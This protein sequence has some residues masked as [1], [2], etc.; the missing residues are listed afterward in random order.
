VFSTSTC[1]FYEKLQSDSNK[2]LYL[3]CTTFPQLLAMLA[4][5]NLKARFGWSDKSF[6]E[7]LVS[8]KKML[9]ED[10]MSCGYGVLENTCMP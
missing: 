10:I 3:G 6:I 1:T 9:P 4:L 8:L 7:S 5:V 2:P